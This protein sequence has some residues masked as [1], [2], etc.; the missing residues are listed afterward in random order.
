MRNSDPSSARFWS[1][2]DVG[3]GWTPEVG[4]DNNALIMSSGGLPCI[5]F[6]CDMC[7][8][9]HSCR[10]V[11][12]TDESLSFERLDELDC[13]RMSAGDG[14]PARSPAE[15]ESRWE[16]EAATIPS[17]D[18]LWANASRSTLSRYCFL[19]YS[20]ARSRLPSSSDGVMLISENHFSAG[21]IWS[22]KANYRFHRY[23]RGLDRPL[24]WCW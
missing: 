23:L 18:L 1:F 13:K 2:V 12:A 6:S 7:L 5:K 24:G 22:D 20:R 15:S 4:A 17:A 21:R 16:S 14:S 10:V 3:F 11:T 9:S 8:R 19:R